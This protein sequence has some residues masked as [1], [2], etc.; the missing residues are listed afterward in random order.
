MA[1][2]R[3]EWFGSELHD[4]CVFLPLVLNTRAI[5]FFLQISAEDNPR[6]V[7]I[8][9]RG[10]VLQYFYKTLA[11]YFCLFR[12][13]IPP[14]G[15]DE[16]VRIHTHTGLSALMFAAAAAHD[17]P[18]RQRAAESDEH[19]DTLLPPGSQKGDSLAFVRRAQCGLRL[20]FVCVRRG[21]RLRMS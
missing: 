9:A 16:S 19:A 6:R 2:W 3:I 18:L 13:W 11:T 8:P 1:Y 15:E 10:F 5:F 7:Y 17:S 4:I 20:G 12:L 21:E 14:E